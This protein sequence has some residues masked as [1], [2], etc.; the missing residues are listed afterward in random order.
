MKGAILLLLA[1][2]A[3]ASFAVL[4]LGGPDSGQAS[5]H[6]EARA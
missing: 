3:A 1:V 4:R 5:S 6:R 2:S